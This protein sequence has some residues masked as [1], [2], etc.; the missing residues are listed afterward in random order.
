MARNPDGS[1]LAITHAVRSTDTHG[2][3]R[4]RELTDQLIFPVLL[5]VHGRVVYANEAAHQLMGVTDLTELAERMERLDHVR[6]DDRPRLR[7]LLASLERG[8]ASSG[9]Q[10]WVVRP[11]GSER[12]VEWRSLHTHVRGVRCILLVANDLTEISASRDALAA[13][14]AHQ[15]SIFEAL[16]EGV[17]VVDALGRCTDANESAATILRLGSAEELLGAP[18]E[19]LPLVARDASPIER[20]AHPLWRALDHGH[21]TECEIWGVRFDQRVRWMRVSVHPVFDV[22]QPAATGAVIT[23]TDATDELDAYDQLA[24]SEQRFHELSRLSP[25]GIFETDANGSCTWVNDTW[26]GFTGLDIEAAAGDGWLAGIH[27]DDRERVM[28][29]WSAAADD[30]EPTFTSDMRYRHVTTGLVT[31]V[32][33][34]AAP[35]PTEDGHVRSWLG[36]AVDMNTEHAL[37]DELRDSERRFRE[38]AERSPDVVLRINLDPFRVDYASR[39]S[40]TVLGRTPQELY[41]EPS[42]I[43]SMVHPDDQAEVINRGP[44][45]APS[46]YRPIR[47]VHPD[48]TIRWVEARANVILDDTGRPYARETTMRDVTDTVTAAELLEHAANTDTLTGL[49]SR[50]AITAAIESRI[51]AGDATSVLF[52]DLDGFKSVNDTHGHDAGDTVL[53]AIAR[54]LRRAVRRDDLVGRFAGDE[55]IVIADPPH[56]ASIAERILAGVTDPITLDDGHQAHVGVSIGMTTIADGDDLAQVLRRA[57]AAMY[58]V[59]RN[60]KG[61]LAQR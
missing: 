51:A 13:S 9:S 50:R 1:V 46:N 24:A 59:K 35:M 53:I 58:D 18:A 23:F 5:Q 3:R 2:D 61:H 56:A 8:E 12:L 28:R 20:A 30:V 25:V 22:L 32:H 57:D 60:G 6:P 36:V 34:T 49:L 16:A 14:E 38:L 21:F 17:I 29:T 26:P 54:R 19:L 44:G 37:R 45:S 48:G 33:V 39:S 55:F 40:A 41:E 15:R 31:S 4:Q 43:L 10:W 52:L 7:Q 11:D 27:P 42:L 47:I